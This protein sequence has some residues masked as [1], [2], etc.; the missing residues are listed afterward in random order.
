MADEDTDPTAGPAAA[1]DGTDS[2]EQPLT[3]PGPLADEARRLLSAVQDWAQ[4]TMPEPTSGHPAECQ[5]CPLCQFASILRG[6]HPEVTERLAEAGT[7]L[8]GAF[9]S[10][11]DAA[12]KHD[13]APNG[14]DGPPRP[15]PRPEP[16]VQHIR[17]VD[18]S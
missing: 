17:L 3:G 14:Q 11:L 12:T 7:A 18:E 15:R 5:W 13:T 1:E 8:A 9:R 2:S 10:F 16:R 4:R 6:E